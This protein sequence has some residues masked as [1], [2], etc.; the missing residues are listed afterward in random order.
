MDDKL[1]LDLG[2]S[3]VKQKDKNMVS[4]GQYW[5]PV[6][7]AYLFPRGESFDDIKTFERYDQSLGLLP[8]LLMVH[9]ILTGLL[10]AI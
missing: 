1:Q 4:Q 3:Y 2:A 5:N 10:T 9:R 8:M 6:I 7:S